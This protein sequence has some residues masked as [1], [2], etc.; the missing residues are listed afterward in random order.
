MKFS[1]VC[2]AAALLLVSG[3]GGKAKADG[4]W[5]AFYGP[6]TYNCGFHSYEQCLETIRGIGGICRP[7]FFSRYRPR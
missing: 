1:I 5:C 6:S 3:M 2:A 4:P 7:N